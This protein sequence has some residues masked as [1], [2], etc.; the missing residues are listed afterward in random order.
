MALIATKELIA[1]HIYRDEIVGL[2]SPNGASNSTLLHATTGLVLWKKGI[3][4]GTSE[5]SITLKGGI[6]FRDEPIEG[7]PAHN[8]SQKRLDSVSRTP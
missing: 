2:I 7:V 6:R 5:G 8:I 3:K 1:N 4:R